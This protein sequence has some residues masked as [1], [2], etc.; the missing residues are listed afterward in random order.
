MQNPVSTS[1][2]RNM[3]KSK[4]ERT[5]ITLVEGGPGFRAVN[6]KA[7]CFLWVRHPCSIS[8]LVNLKSGFY[9]ICL[10]VIEDRIH[11]LDLE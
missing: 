3:K 11:S 7:L 6:L 1:I 2:S 4:A 9:S 8:S 10:S 5:H